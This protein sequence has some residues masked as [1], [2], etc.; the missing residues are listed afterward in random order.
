MWGKRGHI[1]IGI[2][3]DNK[4]E[5]PYNVKTNFFLITELGSV[6][7]F[8]AQLDELIQGTSKKAGGI[9]YTSV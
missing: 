9:I 6:D 4:L 8:V 7:E 1:A 3:S 2:S 5:A